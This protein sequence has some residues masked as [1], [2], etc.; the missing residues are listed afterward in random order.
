MTTMSYDEHCAAMDAVHEGRAT[1]LWQCPVCA[2]GSPPRGVAK[3]AVVG[4]QD[5]TEVITL[6]CGHVVL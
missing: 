5:P 4:V 3:R 2:P 1:E 6:T